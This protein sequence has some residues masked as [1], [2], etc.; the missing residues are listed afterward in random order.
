[1]FGSLALDHARAAL[2]SIRRD[3]EDRATD[4]LRYVF[5][6]V[7]SG[8][9]GLS[10]GLDGLGGRICSFDCLYCEAG[11]TEA[12]T[13]ARKPYVPA[14]RLL[15]E[16]ATWKAAAH[17]LP[18]VV[19]LGG[20]GEPTLNTDCGAILAGARELFSGLPAAVL[21][22]SSLLPDPEVRQ[23]L[24]QADIVLPSMD[25]LVESE[26][27]RL[28]RP[29]PDLTLGAVR[30]GLLDFRSGYAGR[31]FLEVLLVAGINDT[32]ENL[33][34]L[35]DYCRELAPDRVDVTTMSRPGAHAG[36]GPVTPA[37]LA[38]F[39]EALG[40]ATAPATASGHGPASVLAGAPTE[41]LAARIAASVRRRPQTAHAL[42]QGLDVPLEQI[43]QALRTLTRAGTVR[44]ELLGHDTF[45]SG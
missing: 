15:A 33:A 8:R 27:S 42:A 28:N 41:D 45:Y 14:G 36:A 4:H 13:R 16:L 38:Q 18:D 1:M 5:G 37:T 7:E 11:P 10:L 31:I 26:F 12:L 35:R 20:M 21:T 23:A 19:T 39:R 34:L 43:E 6:P 24:A 30:Q 9:L 25:S 2:S 44:R 3:K 40:A 29:H 22:N 17:H 32:E